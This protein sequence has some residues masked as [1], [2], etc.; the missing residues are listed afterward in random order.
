M[1]TNLAMEVQGNVFDVNMSLPSNYQQNEYVMEG[2]CKKIRFVKKSKP[3]FFKIAS[4]STPVSVHAIHFQGKAKKYI[5]KYLSGWKSLSM[6]RRE[7]RSM[8]HTL[9]KRAHLLRLFGVQ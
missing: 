9:R 1:I 3:V 6:Y 7:L 8:Y 2:N 5:P 4:P